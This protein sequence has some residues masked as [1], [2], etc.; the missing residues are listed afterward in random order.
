[1][2]LQ[3]TRWQLQKAG[4][5]LTVQRELLI[6]LVL[7]Q[8]ATL[9]SLPACHY[10]SSRQGQHEVWLTVLAERDPA[11]AEIVALDTQFAKDLATKCTSDTD[12]LLDGAAAEY[13]IGLQHTTDLALDLLSVDGFQSHQRFLVVTMCQG[14]ADPGTLEAYSVAH[15]TTHR[16]LSPEDRAV[17]WRG[18]Y[19]PGHRPELSFYGHWLWNI[20]VGPQPMPGQDPWA[21]LVQLGA[22]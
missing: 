13:R 10:Y 22:I 3:L 1:M 11:P 6:A 15:S 14:L 20:V 7:P 2:A 5:P 21:L 8:L 16:T 4:T 19:V 9:R 17:F 18:F 12:A